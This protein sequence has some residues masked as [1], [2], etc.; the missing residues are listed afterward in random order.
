MSSNWVDV[1]F[2]TLKLG[3]KSIDKRAHFILDV[4]AQQPSASIPQAFNSWSEI[5]GCYRFFEN[6]LVD[7]QKIITPH[8]Q[9]TINRIKEH[10]VVLIPSD[11]TC[12]N[13][14]NKKSMSGL[15]DIEHTKIAKGLWAH[16]SLAITPERVTLGVSHVKLWARAKQEKIPEYAVYGLPIKDK[17]LYKWIESYQSACEIAVE[18]P[19]T[20]IINLLDREGDFADFFEEVNKYQQH[21]HYAEVVVRAKFDRI[22]QKGSKEKKKLYALLKEEP[23]LGQIR[24]VLPESKDYK[25]RTVFQT[26]KAMTIRFKKRSLKGQNS[27]YVK[28]NVVAAVEENPPEG[29]NPISWLFLTTLPIDSIEKTIKVI[30]YYLARWEIETFFKVLKSGCKIEQRQLNSAFK[31]ESLIS[32]YL[33]IAWRIMHVMMVG[34][35]HP[36]ITCSTVF[37]EDEWQAA[38]KVYYKG[39]PLPKETPTLGECIKIIASFGGYLNRRTDGPPGVKV[40]WTGL[41]RLVDFTLAWELFKRE[42]NLSI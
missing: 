2:E 11:T 4:L 9:A 35:I 12:L 39:K 40:M 32:L 23:E 27:P 34:R 19:D 6:D 13:Y 20:K 18:C 21:D 28:M 26:I 42:H 8:Q 22:I 37:S 7:P 5:K 10:K 17:E 38:Y 30:E 24:F 3:H 41:Q 36:N 1:E 16:C 31:M 15:G 25:S 29:E 14:S 33:I